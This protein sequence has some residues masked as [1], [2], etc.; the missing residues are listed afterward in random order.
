M[1]VDATT[2]FVKSLNWEAKSFEATRDYAIVTAHGHEAREILDCFESDWHRRPF[3]PGEDSHP[4]LVP[5]QRS[6]LHRSVTDGRE[7]RLPWL[8][9]E[10][11]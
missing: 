7:S 6:R 9:N 3:E 2:A 5:H 10:R 4:H 8:Q 1:V 11:Y